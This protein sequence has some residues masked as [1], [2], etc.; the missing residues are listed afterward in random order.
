MLCAVAFVFVGRHCVVLV[1]V[2]NVVVSLTLSAWL[3]VVVC[4]DLLRMLSAGRCT[5]GECVS[6]VWHDVLND[7]GVCDIWCIVC[8]LGCVVQ[9]KRS[10]GIGDG[11][12]LCNQLIHCIYVSEIILSQSFLYLCPA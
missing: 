2:M 6:L 3:D 1:T 5:G 4:W 7:V 11:Y 8:E 10:C 12:L 9:C